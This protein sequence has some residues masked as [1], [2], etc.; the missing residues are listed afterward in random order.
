M[1]KLLT[2]LFFALSITNVN[3]TSD[4]NFYTGDDKVP[5]DNMQIYD[6]QFAS[7][8][9]QYTEEE[10]TKVITYIEMR[11]WQQIKLLKEK[12]VTLLL[13][14]DQEK[15]LVGASWFRTVGDALFMRQTN[16]NSPEVYL[17]IVDNLFKC[18]EGVRALTLKIP[19]IRLNAFKPLFD[20]LKSINVNAEETS[21]FDD[22]DKSFA[23]DLN[24]SY[25]RL[26]RTDQ[27]E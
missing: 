1:R 11:I 18:Q 22:D 4:V 17:S 24:W 27:S 14:T 3:A 9:A 16:A 15:N 2:I 5:F 23:E 13:V 21:A 19:D 12:A 25:W 7:S 26:T 8:R 20:R 6:F 10:L